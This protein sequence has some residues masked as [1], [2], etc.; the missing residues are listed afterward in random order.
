MLPV[1]F[2]INLTIENSKNTLY[3]LEY[4]FGQYLT[5][6]HLMGTVNILLNLSLFRPVLVMTPTYIIILAQKNNQ[7][8][9]VTDYLHLF[10]KKF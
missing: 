10:S 4:R 7:T 1:S 3:L 6:Q 9:K 8:L 5:Y 2:P